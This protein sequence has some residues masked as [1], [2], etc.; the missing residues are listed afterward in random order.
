M[1][2]DVRE[3]VAYFSALFLARPVRYLD[4]PTERDHYRA[5]DDV[6][7]RA[8]G[9][10]LYV[11]QTKGLRFRLPYESILYFRSDRNYVTVHL[12]DRTEHSFPGKLA[13]VERQVP[14]HLFVRVH[15]SYLVN[16][17]A[18]RLIDK[19]KKSVRL[20]NGEE[21]FISRAHYQDTL[22]I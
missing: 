12:R 16:R 7:C 1:P 9:K 21:I 15:Q 19:G 6:M 18:V 5:V 2:R 11:C 20:S 22:E 17:A 8:A 14:K 13:N 3:T 4:R 10:G